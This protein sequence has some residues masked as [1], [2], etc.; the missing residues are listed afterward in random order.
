MILATLTQDGWTGLSFE[1]LYT[2]DLVLITEDERGAEEKIR[3]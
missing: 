3:R 1:L 2:D